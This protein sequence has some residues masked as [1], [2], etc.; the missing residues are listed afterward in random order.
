M[1]RGCGEKTGRVRDRLARALRLQLRHL[2][3]C[4]PDANNAV[5]LAGYQA[6]GTHG[7]S[8]LEGVPAVKMPGRYV[9]VRAEIVD[10]PA[11]SVRAD[12]QEIIGWLGKAPSPPETCYVVQGDPEAAAALCREIRTQLRWNAVVPRHLEQARLD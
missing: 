4:L 9:P 1:F 8:L 7:R 5:I 10:V 2:E 12:Q 6:L 3:R 11:F